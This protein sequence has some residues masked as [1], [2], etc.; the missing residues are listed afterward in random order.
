MVKPTRLTQDM[1]DDYIDRGYWDELSI[2]DI[3]RRNAER[4]PDKEAVVDSETRLTW[5]E[6]E[7]KAN[8]IAVGL[9]KSGMKRDQAMMA[10]LPSSAT[11]LLLLLA[12]H[13]AGILCCLSP[14]TFRYNE[15]KHI[16]TTI[17]AVALVTPWEYRGVDYFTMASEIARDVPELTPFLVTGKDVPRGGRP[18]RSLC[19]EPFE[20]DNHEEY[21]R[22][23]AFSPFE[24]SAFVLS[25]GT[26]GMPKCIEHTGAS[27]KSAGWGVVQRAKLTEDDIIGNIAPLS[28][29]PGLQN[30]WSAFQVGAKTCL[31]EHFSPDEACELIQ[32]EGITYLSAIPTQLIRMLK[33]SDLDRYDLSTL[34]VIRTGAAAFDASLAGETEQR[35]NCKVLIAGGS[36]ET[37]SFA[38][39][40][41]DDPREKRL[42]TLGKPFPGNEIKI[43]DNE[44]WE[45]PVG[46]IGQL[47]VRGAAASSGYYGDV[48]ATLAAWGT[49][50]NEGW[51]NTGDLARI[52][53]QGYLALVGRKKEMIIRGGQNIY[54][55]EIEDLLL[56]H[57]TVRQA[58]VIGIPDLVM[59]ERVCACV[60]P[61][62]GNG[63]SFEE[64]T[65]FLKNKGLAVHKLP[66][67]LMVMEHF[68]Q[69]ADGQKVDKITLR[70]MIPEKGDQNG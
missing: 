14:M 37:F 42:R 19:E 4:S 10:Q 32:R 24:V 55:G 52:D 54:P 60:A 1:I 65:S 34:R 13:R 70:N 30:W 53:E 16:A 9:L 39:S 21:L 15:L 48:E 61:V 63:I 25:S 12:G 41:V 28:G 11:S 57:P 66:E 35:F 22:G 59:G 20:R 40:G 23:K 17:K 3:L 31:L 36:Q 46:Q 26:T 18:F 51:F 5:A 2:P 43:L 29:G 64:M 67:R 38:Q 49:I 50:G 58:V 45:V 68:P 7:E 8:R 62:V 47:F 69:L 56:S 6:L 33:E 44:G 27:F